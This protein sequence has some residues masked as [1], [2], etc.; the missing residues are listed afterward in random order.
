MRLSL[1]FSLSVTLCVM[2]ATTATAEVYKTVD[3]QGRVTYTDLPP[4]DTKAKVVELPVINT[5]PE[6]KPTQSVSTSTPVAPDIVYQLTIVAPEDGTNLTPGD[7]N[8][9][10]SVSVSPGLNNGLM[11]SYFLNDSL[12]ERTTESTIT[13]TEPPRGEHQLTVEVTDEEG[14]SFGKSPAVTIVVLRPSLLQKKPIVPA[15]K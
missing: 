15:K 10:I 13:L 4:S 11:L 2:I 8:V 6:T 7:R 12:I 9:D 1:A 3:K 14:K 5:V